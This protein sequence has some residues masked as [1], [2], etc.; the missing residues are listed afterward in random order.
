MDYGVCLLKP[1]CIVALISYHVKKKKKK[2]TL[3]LWSTKFQFPTN[4]PLLFLV[5]IDFIL[6]LF[7]FSFGHVN[8]YKK[9]RLMGGWG[10]GGEEGREGMEGGR[11]KEKGAGGRRN[12]EV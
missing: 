2:I 8:S 10:G 5:A 12:P 3:K 6:L 9:E 1:G 7:S 11:G 4:L